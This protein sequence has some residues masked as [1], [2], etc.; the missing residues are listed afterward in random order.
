MKHQ[1]D[2]PLPS[3]KDNSSIQNPQFDI[4]HF[5]SSNALEKKLSEMLPEESNES[6]TVQNAKEIL[7]STYTTEEI[8]ELITSFEYLTTN[9]L[10][11]YE[12]K[13]FEGR[14]LKEILQSV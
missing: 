12:Q 1:N 7:G 5:P 3:L 11:E 2:N 6:K 4:S 14:T 10:E 13:I 9:W 8:K